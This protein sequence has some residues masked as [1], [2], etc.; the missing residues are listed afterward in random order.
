MTLPSDFPLEPPATNKDP[1]RDYRGLDRSKLTPMYQHYV[2]V[3]ETYPNAL[4]LYRVGDFFECFFQDAV[5]ISRELE[6]VLTSKE[7]GKGIGR[8]AM[9]GVPHH[10]LERYSRLLVEKGYAVAICDQVEDS[11]EAAAEKRLVE[12]AITK[13][14]TPGTLTD[15]GMLNAKKNNFLAAVVIT[16]ENWGLA[17]ADISTGEFYT[18]QASDLTALSLELTRLQPSEILFPINAPDLNRI[19][20]P[21]EKSDHL[22]PCLPDSFCYSLRPQTIFTL[23]EAKNRLLITYKM[24]SLEGMGCE[25]LPLAI[26]AA[27]GLLEYIE[28]TQKANQVPLQPLKTYSISEFLILDGQTRRNLEITQT[29][30]D[31]SFY[32]SLLWAIDRTCTAMGSRALRRWLLQ[33]LLDSR[34]IRARQDTIE[35]L[36]DNPSLRQDIRQKLREIYDIERLSGRVGAGTANARD[37]L[38]LAASLV[39]LADLAALVASGNSPYLKALQQIPADL[40]KLGQQVIAHLVESPPLHLKEGGVIREGIDAQLDALRRDYQEVIDWFKNL[41]TTEKERTGI[42]NLKVNYN[43]T[44]GYYISLPRSKAD[45]APKEYV[46]KQTLVN[47]ERYITT[48]LKEKENI[49]L[50]AVD[51]L[52]KLEYEIFSDLRRQVA[53]FSPEI[54][55]V[56]TKVAALDVLAALAEIAVYQGYCRPE[57]ADGRLID[58]KDGRHPVVE[59]SLGAGF[60]VPNSINLGNQEGLEYPDLII[61]TGPNASGKSCYLRQVGLI[62]LLAQT[63]SFVP[64]KS[65]KISIC[66][67]IFTRVGAVDDL[68]TGQSTFM[69]E[70]NETANILNHATDRSLVLLDEIGRGTATFDGLSIAWSVAEYLATVLQSRTI[71][72]THYHELNELAS[73]LENVANYQV[74]VKE[75]PHE[76]VFLH[77]VRP[78]GADKSYGIEA[79]R[80]AGLPASVIDRAMQ[81]MGQIEKHS[82]IAIGLRQGIKKIKPVKSDNSP[83]LQQLDIFDDSK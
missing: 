43:K 22:P 8:V 55:E 6:L 19:L 47:E 39:K 15:E 81:V 54:R 69:V 67:R 27:G 56:A 32:G 79:G 75:L 7:G 33:P 44:F 10:A 63:G 71:F 82:K 13:L 37:L 62:Q 30:R 46:R 40:E 74:T 34:G 11:T 5:I 78:G 12:R 66:D 16:G 51:E 17:Y 18:T 29:V 26:R 31:G 57:I 73:I 59:Q 52:N 61:L 76:I 65:A 2:E 80:L 45:F 72:A 70:M 20:R 3:K 64:A 38:S 21:G 58:I 36:K 4:L 49:I 77:Q 25:H 42:S 83:S 24:R 23:T 53:E 35:E 48:E 60:F 68:A 28:D 50:T 1:H 9:T 41:E 14:L